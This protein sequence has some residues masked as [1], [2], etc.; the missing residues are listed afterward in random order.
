MTAVV[1]AD[2]SAIS[3][4]ASLGVSARSCSAET[5]P[6]VNV[7]DATEASSAAAG[8]ETAAQSRVSSFKA[9]AFSAPEQLASSS[10]SDSTTGETLGASETVSLDEEWQQF[11][12][13]NEFMENLN[14]QKVTHPYFNPC[15][16][17]IHFHNHSLK[18][19]RVTVRV[20]GAK[21]PVCQCI[22]WCSSLLR[23]QTQHP[24][25]EGDKRQLV[26][27]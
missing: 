12:E 18:A 22:T 8:V 15:Q 4:D 23:I 21:K 19:G 7:A 26:L 5:V 3:S 9:D 10:P 2:V 11:N 20:A 24:P 13:C 27:V 1:E 25:Q 14:F 16:K 17:S 6:S